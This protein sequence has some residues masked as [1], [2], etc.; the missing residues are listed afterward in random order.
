MATQKAFASYQEVIDLHTESDTVTA[1]GIHTPQ[2]DTPRKM[3]GGFFDQ[4]K[5][6][7][8]LGASIVM[9]PAAR[10]PVDPLGVSYEA[11]EPT[12]DPRDL[13]NP[14]LWH[15]CHGNDMGSIL[16]KLYGNP[17]YDNASDSLDVQVS[18]E[19]TSVPDW[20]ATMQRLY[21][22]A[23]TDNT[24]KKA[25]PQ[26]GFKKTGLRPLVYSLAS[27]R[28]IAPGTSVTGIGSDKN[29]LMG[30]NVSGDFDIAGDSF[31]GSLSNG[32]WSST[33]TRF[34]PQFV[35][36][37][38][39]SLGWLDTRNVLHGTALVSDP[40]TSAT[41]GQPTLETQKAIAL[42]NDT[43]L[44][45]IYMGMIL[46]PPAYKTEQYFRLIINHHFG[47]KGFR[48]VSMD[49]SQAGIYAF[50]DNYVNANEGFESSDVTNGVPVTINVTNN[51]QV[52]AL[53]GAVVTI[54]GSE[55]TFNV[56]VGS[57]YNVVTDWNTSPGTTVT[58][59][60]SGVSPKTE[61]VVPSG[62]GTLTIAVNNSGAVSGGWQ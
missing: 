4:F 16:N 60:V 57:T 22:Q 45:K 32:A 41:D 62:G 28:Q 50:P 34:T 29:D 53:T 58:F 47:F 30:V 23:L 37:R 14:I 21:Y 51:R 1:I 39:T 6:F 19:I 17:T 2:G 13:M 12:I 48:G 42:Q 24:W 11:G 18:Q 38:L 56:P 61:F 40:I 26:K 52:A 54:G 9:V 27:T 15:G 25:H 36:P 31:G 8:Y 5:K 43:V 3:F 59:E 7:R 44:P 35:T 20:V 10:L 49:N 55:F 33:E 46:L